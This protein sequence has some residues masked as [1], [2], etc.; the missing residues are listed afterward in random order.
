MP[1]VM[2]AKMQDHHRDVN[3]RVLIHRVEVPSE[4][5]EEM[6]KMAHGVSETLRLVFFLLK[7][8]I[9]YMWNSYP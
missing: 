4:E 3:N 7:P 2:A 8:L 5:H 6:N 9:R 1:T